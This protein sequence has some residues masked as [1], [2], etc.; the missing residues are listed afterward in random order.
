MR[1]EVLAFPG[2][3]NRQSA[4]ERLKQVL[5]EEGVPLSVIDIPLLDP[6][7]FPGSPTIRIDGIDID[8]SIASGHSDGLSC[9]TYIHD[10]ICEGIPPAHLIR[11]AVRRARQKELP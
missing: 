7:G 6:G 8:P 4:L 3:A 2:C 5:V 10:G 11:S 1:I 9:R